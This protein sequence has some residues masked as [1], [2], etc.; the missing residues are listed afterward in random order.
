MF[1]PILALG[2]LVR[3]STAVPVGAAVPIIS[4]LL[5][6]MPPLYPPIAFIMS[7]EGAVLGGVA[8]LCYRRWRVGL[9]PSLLL[10][11]G[12]ERLT[13]A[14][15]MIMLAEVFNLK[16]DVVV[17][18]SV[19]SGAPGLVL[20]IVLVPYVVRRLEARY[21]ALAKGRSNG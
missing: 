12:A 2:F 8:A 16:T 15:L 11:V 19:L 13:L 5:T 18:V 4:A 6:G 7:C 1:L 3:W 17:V 9:W 14:I 10:A 20:Q 21:P